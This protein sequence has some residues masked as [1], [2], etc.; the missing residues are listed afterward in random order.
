MARINIF[1][2]VS[3]AD[4]QVSWTARKQVGV[5]S[6]MLAF[7]KH[8]KLSLSWANAADEWRFVWAVQGTQF[9][10]QERSTITWSDKVVHCH[11]LGKKETEAKGTKLSMV[12]L[13]LGSRMVED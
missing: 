12:Q 10:T 1:K 3:A 11:Y 13:I 8:R 6:T 9:L 5:G 7:I 2:T 4:S